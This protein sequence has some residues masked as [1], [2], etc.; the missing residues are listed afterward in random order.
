MSSRLAVRPNRRNHHHQQHQH[1]LCTY[2]CNLSHHLA[3]GVRPPKMKHEKINDAHVRSANLP[4]LSYFN[5]YFHTIAERGGS[6]LSAVCEACVCAA[7]V[8]CVCDRFMDTRAKVPRGQIHARV[9]ASY[10]R[11]ISK[12][13]TG[14]NHHRGI[15]A[16]RS[17]ERFDRFRCIGHRVDEP[18]R[19]AAR[20]AIGPL[21]LEVSV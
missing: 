6:Y 17:I 4:S 14:C 13:A 18:V 19:D 7:L 8:V 21:A 15:A 9:H 3:C 11:T 20:H 2:V 1:L 10:V 12:P 5:V 16:Y